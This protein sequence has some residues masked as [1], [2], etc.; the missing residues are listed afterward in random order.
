MTI[1]QA[2]S[3]L[4]S[5]FRVSMTVIRPSENNPLKFSAHGEDAIKQLL[6]GDDAAFLDPIAAVKESFEDIGNHQMAL[7]AGIQSSLM[8]LL[9]RF[10]PE[11][12]EKRFDR[13][14]A[15]GRQAKS[16]N[17]YREAYDGIVR[18]IM[19]EIFGTAFSRAY[20]QQIQKLRS[21]RK[22]E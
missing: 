18:E 3:E 1:L 14:L 4:K 9:K 8:T 6:R 22:K 19:E 15:I 11:H 10:D 13:G 7:A 12:F 17:A 20:E 2:R 16:W 5:Q 21:A